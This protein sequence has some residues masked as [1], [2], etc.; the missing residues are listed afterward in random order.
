MRNMNLREYLMDS[1]I[2]IRLAC[3]NVEGWPILVSLWY[4]Y[5]EGKSFVLLKEMPRS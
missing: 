1:C 3:I 4:V 2:P 5:L